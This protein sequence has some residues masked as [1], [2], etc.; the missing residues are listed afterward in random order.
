[1]IYHAVLCFNAEESGDGD[2]ITNDDAAVNGGAVV[3]D[4]DVER[5]LV[6]VSAKHCATSKTSLFKIFI[7]FTY[8]K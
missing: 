4:G 6:V 1:V 8:K 3:N 5:E 2:A 7:S